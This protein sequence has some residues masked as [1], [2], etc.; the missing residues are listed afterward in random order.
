M[1]VYKNSNYIKHHKPIA[2]LPSYL[3][4]IHQVLKPTPFMSC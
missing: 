2:E 1:T 4:L 3:H